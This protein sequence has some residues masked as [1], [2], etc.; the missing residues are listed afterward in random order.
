[1]IGKVLGAVAGLQIAGHTS[2]VSGPMGA[3][4]GASSVAL[5]RRLSI[6][7]LLALTVGG[8]AFKK[9]QDKRDADAAKRKS[10][11]TPPNAATA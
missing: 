10:F 2:S 4:L 1:M 7:T 8:Y 5:I 3:V 11:E 6:P 9:W